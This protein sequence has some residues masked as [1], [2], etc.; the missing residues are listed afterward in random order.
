MSTSTVYRDR[1][2]RETGLAPKDLILEVQLRALL[3]KE[4]PRF[5]A[6]N[7]EPIFQMLLSRHVDGII[8]AIPEVGENFNWINKSLI[9][10]Q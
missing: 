7:V 5:D 2:A 6:N 8:W 1:L 10:S 4:L 9:D 3:L